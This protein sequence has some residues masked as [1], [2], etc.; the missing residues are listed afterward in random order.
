MLKLELVFII[1]LIAFSHFPPSWF[2]LPQVHIEEW[3]FLLLLD[4]AFP[5]P[6]FPLLWGLKSLQD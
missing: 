4:S 3:E 1:L 5:L 2:P 6:D